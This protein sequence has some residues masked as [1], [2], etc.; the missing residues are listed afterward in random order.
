MPCKCNAMQCINAT[1]LHN[2]MCSV[3]QNNKIILISCSLPP[4]LKMLDQ[5]N[6]RRSRPK[7]RQLQVSHTSITKLVGTW[8]PSL[9]IAPINTILE[10]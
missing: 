9:N 7:L 2:P 4:H 6:L 8:K 5:Y 10:T 3:R 1:T